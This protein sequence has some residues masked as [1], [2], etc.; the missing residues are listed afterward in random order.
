MSGCGTAEKEFSSFLPTDPSFVFRT[1]SRGENTAT[2]RSQYNMRQFG[3]VFQ[4][5][6]HKIVLGAVIKPDACLRIETNSEGIFTMVSTQSV[7]LQLEWSSIN[8]SET[9]KQDWKNHWSF[10]VEEKRY[11]TSND[12]TKISYYVDEGKEKQTAEKIRQ[13]IEQLM[14]E[15]KIKP[16]PRFNIKEFSQ[17]RQAQTVFAKPTKQEHK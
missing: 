7:S 5:L 16:V 1:P 12:S 15:N 17:R 11:I 10:S 14:I 3:Q 2:L 13:F 6:A 4:R 9:P 8:Y